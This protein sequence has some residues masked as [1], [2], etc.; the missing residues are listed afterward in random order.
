MSKLTKS[1]E[2]ICAEIKKISNIEDDKS[3]TDKFNALFDKLIQSMNS[4]DRMSLIRCIDKYTPINIGLNV[5]NEE[6]S[7][8]K[9]GITGHSD[10]KNLIILTINNNCP[11]CPPDENPKIFKRIYPDDDCNCE[12]SEND[13]SEDEST[14]ET[15]ATA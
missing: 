7:V 2:T 15:N 12:D 13:K 8:Y 9:M 1:V 6:E 4:R 10:E 11:C 5:V 14:G 3:H